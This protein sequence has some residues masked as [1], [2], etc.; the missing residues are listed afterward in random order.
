[1]L[2]KALRWSR[3]PVHRWYDTTFGEH[4]VTNAITR[5]FAPALQ[6]DSEA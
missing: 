5:A 1:M 3:V 4:S 6:V 2:V